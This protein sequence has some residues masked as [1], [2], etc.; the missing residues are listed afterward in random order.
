MTTGRINQVSIVMFI[1]TSDAFMRPVLERLNILTGVVRACALRPRW[2]GRSDFRRGCSPAATPPY[3][4]TF[5]LSSSERFPQGLYPRS[6]SVVRSPLGCATRFPNMFGL[7]QEPG[8]KVG[9][10]FPREP[11]SSHSPLVPPRAALSLST[12]ARSR[13]WFMASLF[14]NLRFSHRVSIQA[15]STFVAP[16][17]LIYSRDDNWP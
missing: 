10:R 15:T 2:V 1:A 16:L 14:C 9:H 5:S 13:V 4:P 7:D 17:D 3:G 8:T 11:L 6:G 12:A